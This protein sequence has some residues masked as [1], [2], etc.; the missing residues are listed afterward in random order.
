MK[1]LGLDQYAAPSKIV[2]YGGSVE[3]TIEIGEAL[4]CPI[5]HRGVDDRAGKA[6]RMKELMEGRSRVIAATNALGLG[7]DLPDIRVVIHAGQPRKLRDYA[8]ESGRAGRD[9]KSSEAII[10]CGYIEQPRHRLKSWAQSGEEIF[11]FVAGHICR[12]IIM[13]QIM[14]GRMDQ[15]GCEEGEEQCDV[16]RRQEM[17]RT[18]RMEGIDGMDRVDKT[19]GI[20]RAD[21]MEMTSNI[22][23][24]DSGIGKSMSSQVESIIQSTTPIPSSPISEDQGFMDHSPIPG[25]YQSPEET[26]MQTLF[27]QQQ[28]ERQWLVSSVTKQNREE[29]QEIAE[30][31]EALRKWANGCPLCRVEKRR[32]HQHQLEECH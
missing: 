28:R 19:N 31:E 1:G 4:E 7:V 9:G 21:G 27:E 16:C 5:Y 11:D 26:Q 32:N 30:F 20:E 10:V 15:V 29:G 3:Q 25:R 24:E 22:G 17:D 6:R 8:Q 13:D 23:F 18:D 14:D 12:R 2:V